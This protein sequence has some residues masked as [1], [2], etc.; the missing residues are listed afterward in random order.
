MENQRTEISIYVACLASYNN[1]ILHG[2]W[3]CAE[4]GLEHIQ[5][6]VRLMLKASPVEGAEEYAIHDYEGFEGIQ[7]SEYE[8]FGQIVEYAEYLNEH[9]TLGAKL[10]EHYGNLDDANTALSD[11]YAGHYSSVAEY[12]EQI[13]EETTTIPQ[14]LTYY[15]DYEKMARD[16]EVNDIV[17]VETNFEEVHIFWQH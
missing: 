12:A 10:V 5:S 4:S 8:G 6:K 17:A 14:S 9:G 11:H 1:G 3:I 13:T 15:I 16:M 7:L 2:E